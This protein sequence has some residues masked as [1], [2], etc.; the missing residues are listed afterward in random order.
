MVELLDALVVGTHGIS[1]K[2]HHVGRLLRSKSWLVR[3]AGD[4]VQVFHG[5]LKIF[6][7]KNLKGKCA[8]VCS[9]FTTCGNPVK[10]QSSRFPSWTT[11]PPRSALVTDLQS[12]RAR[13]HCR[14]ITNSSRKFL[15]DGKS[16]IFR[17][18]SAL[19]TPS[20][21]GKVGIDPGV[22]HSNY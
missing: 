21:R 15:L 11:P 13:R 17:P 6:H 7:I 14:G 3:P 1:S 16:A 4:L 5:E 12:P 10:R 18:R 20:G 8:V 2:I 19:V 9:F 22:P